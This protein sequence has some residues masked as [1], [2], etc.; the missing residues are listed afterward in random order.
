MK[1]C[2][3]CGRLAPEDQIERPADY[4]HH[5]VLDEPKAPITTD[6]FFAL[7]I[8]GLVRVVSE[9]GP[10]GTTIRRP[11]MS[12]ASAFTVDPDTVFIGFS[13]DDHVFVLGADEE[14]FC[15]RPL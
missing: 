14:G 13:A 5:D 11:V 7:P 3:Y 4:C 8:R 1:R 10:N 2:P 15:R 12:K 6:E 9:P